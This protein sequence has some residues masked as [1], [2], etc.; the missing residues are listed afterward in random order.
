MNTEKHCPACGAPAQ[1]AETPVP[2]PTM[3]TKERGS[4]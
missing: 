4:E 2:A 1:C 3:N